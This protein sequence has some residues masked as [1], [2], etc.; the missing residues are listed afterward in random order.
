EKSRES[1]EAQAYYVENLMTRV[2]QL[3][4]GGTL[5][6]EEKYNLTKLNSIQAARVYMGLFSPSRQADPAVMD[7]LNN[8]AEEEGDSDEVNEA[9]REKRLRKRWIMF[10]ITGNPWYA[11][12]DFIA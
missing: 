7:I 1:G 6:D 9:N 4:N 5:A 8:L 12:E 11:R 10:V 2:K 3:I